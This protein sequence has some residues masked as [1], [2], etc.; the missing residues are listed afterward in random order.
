MPIY[1]VRSFLRVFQADGWKSPEPMMLSCSPRG[2]GVRSSA[3]PCSSLFFAHL[4]LVAAVCS[5]S[6]MTGPHPCRLPH[7]GSRCNK[8]PRAS[9]F[10]ICF[11]LAIGVILF[12]DGNSACFVDRPLRIAVGA[13]FKTGL[14][15]R[16]LCLALSWPSAHDA[17]LVWLYFLLAAGVQRK[18]AL[19]TLLVTIVLCV[20][21]LWV[22]HIAPDGCRSCD[23][24]YRQ[25]RRTEASTTRT[26]R[27]R[28][29][30]SRPHHRSCRRSSSVFDDDPRIYVPLSYLVSA[31]LLLPWMF[32]TVRTRFS[33][34]RACLASRPSRP[35]H[36]GHYHRQTRRQAAAAH[37]PA[38]ACYGQ[39]GPIGW[40]ALLA[41]SAALFVTGDIQPILTILAGHVPGSWILQSLESSPP[42]PYRPLILLVIAIFTF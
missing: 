10:L 32:S 35:S 24:T 33:Q 11:L 14:V 39:R 3:T 6:L 30:P 9:L 27:H 22:S 37:G 5:G 12:A 1:T 21:V 4:P 26:R 2:A 36:A 17:G 13:S 20:R 31:A 34:H 8:A 41:T 23:P 42:G 18:R 28:L 29:S 40:F 38:C 25:P 19:Q 15:P 16:L 7:L